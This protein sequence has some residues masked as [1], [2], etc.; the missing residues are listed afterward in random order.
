M[1]SYVTRGSNNI[2]TE[3]IPIGVCSEDAV[4]DLDTNT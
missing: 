1:V 4:G 2:K 3:K